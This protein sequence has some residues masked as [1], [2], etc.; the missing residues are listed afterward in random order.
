[1]T[2]AVLLAFL[3]SVFAVPGATSIVTSVIRRLTDKLGIDPRV[4]VYI[5]AYALSG[6]IM[7]SANLPAWADDPFLFVAAWSGVATATAEMAR[8]LY[9]AILK[10]L[11]GLA[12]TPA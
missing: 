9:D 3:A 1:M 12:P 4:I 11:P 2:E 7:A 8:R 5:V 10:F 6:W